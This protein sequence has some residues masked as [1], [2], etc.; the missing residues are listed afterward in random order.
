MKHNFTNIE[1]GDKSKSERQ[2]TA[3]S[4]DSNLRPLHLEQPFDLSE[5]NYQEFNCKT[6]SSI[7]DA[8]SLRLPSMNDADPANYSLNFRSSVIN[9]DRLKSKSK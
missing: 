3:E 8:N 7:D 4:A 1:K 5:A 6:V 2:Q 9:G